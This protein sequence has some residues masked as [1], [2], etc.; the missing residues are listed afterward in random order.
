MIL[1]EFP[2]SQFWLDLRSEIDKVFVFLVFLELFVVNGS[3]ICGNSIKV[4]WKN[5]TIIYTG[6]LE[7]HTVE[8]GNVCF[9]NTNESRHI[10]RQ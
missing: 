8:C 2:E 7:C 3:P 9:C 4:E 1:D 5:G 6:L 10:V